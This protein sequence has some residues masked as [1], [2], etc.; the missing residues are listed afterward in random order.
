MKKHS[1]ALVFLAVVVII[2]MGLI[3]APRFLLY[4]SSVEKMDAIVLLLGE[5]FNARK[6]QVNM[7]TSK[8]FADYLIIPAYNKTYRF[9]DG[10]V[11]EEFISSSDFSKEIEKNMM[12][13]IIYE[14]THLEIIEAKIIM[15]DYKFK[16][17]VFVSSPYHMRR[18]KIMVYKVFKL[19]EGEFYF[20]P[21]QF[22]KAP[23]NFWELSSK[24]WKNV[25][26]EYLKIIW[27]LVYANFVN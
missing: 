8:R 16:S 26:T 14:N 13:S 27:F 12:R 23:A 4:S 5:D 9:A 10:S 17:V 21:T 7:L 6:K 20:M 1:K 24:D 18:I 2:C 11:A 15:S 25:C 3:F 19:A 22:E